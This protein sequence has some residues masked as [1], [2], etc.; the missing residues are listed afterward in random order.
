MKSTHFEALTYYACFG[1]HC[2]DEVNQEEKAEPATEIFNSGLITETPILQGI[3]GAVTLLLAT[4]FMK[5]LFRIGLLRL[6]IRAGTGQAVN[7]AH[8]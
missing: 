7:F 5:N 2:S 6:W 4:T 8:V 1:R 3:I